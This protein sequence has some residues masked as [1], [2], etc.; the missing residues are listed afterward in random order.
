MSECDRC[1]RLE[2]EIRDIRREL[3]DAEKRAYELE[4]INYKLSAELKPLKEEKE[5]NY[6]NYVT[7]PKGMP[8]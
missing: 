7:T 4:S 1:R 6:D 2:R 8:K 5:R 3:S